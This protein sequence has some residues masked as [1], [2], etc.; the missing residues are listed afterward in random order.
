MSRSHENS[1]ITLIVDFL[2]LAS[3]ASL[4]SQYAERARAE[5]AR[6]QYS[7]NRLQPQSQRS[8]D[9]QDPKFV[10]ES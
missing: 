2:K 7:V 4:V 8:G 10:A 6:S 1:A 5:R 9:E 3:S